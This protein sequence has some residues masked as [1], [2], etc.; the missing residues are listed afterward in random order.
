MTT[1][2][3]GKIRHVVVVFDDL[4]VLSSIDFSENLDAVT[5]F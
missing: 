5:S 2:I 1:Q 3:A 4:K